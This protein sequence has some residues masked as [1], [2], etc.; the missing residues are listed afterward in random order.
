MGPDPPLLIKSTLL[1][2]KVTTPGS[3]SKRKSGAARRIKKRLDA[4]ASSFFSLASGDELLPI[5]KYYP[6]K[7]QHP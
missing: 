6:K 2:T 4:S 5:P 3:S 1:Q 7:I